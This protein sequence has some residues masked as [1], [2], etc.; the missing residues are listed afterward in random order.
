MKSASSDP[1]K[2]QKATNPQRRGQ[3]K[4]QIFES[5]AQTMSSVASKAAEALSKQLKSG[6]SVNDD[7]DG[8]RSPAASAT[9]PPSSSDRLHEQWMWSLVFARRSVGGWGRSSS[10]SHRRIRH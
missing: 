5:F 7:H 3:I 8:V 2:K 4:A 10:G 1:Q 9:P 6:G